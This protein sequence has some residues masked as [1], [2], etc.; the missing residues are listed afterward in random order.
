MKLN[1]FIEE[2]AERFLHL[3]SQFYPGI[4]IIIVIII[5]VVFVIIIIIIPLL[6]VYCLGVNITTIL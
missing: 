1:L 6:R 3:I 4:N 2:F 5:V